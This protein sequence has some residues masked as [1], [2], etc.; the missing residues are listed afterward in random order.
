MG[1]HPVVVMPNS[2]F[3][4]QNLQ[5]HKMRSCQLS[6]LT[7]IRGIGRNRVVSLSATFAFFFAAGLLATLAV[8]KT[9]STGLPQE[10]EKKE[11]ALSW[12]P[13]QVDAPVPS[14]SATPP[15]SLPD[16]LNQAGARANE[17]IDHLQNF[18]AHE[19]IR[20]KQTDRDGAPDMT[21]AA[22]FDYTVD[23]EDQ[24]GQLNIHEARTPLDGT[25]DENLSDLLDK[26]LPALAL[27]FSPALQSDYEMRCDGLTPWNKQPTW[28]VRFRQIKGKRPRTMTMRTTTGAYPLALKGRAWIAKDS[29]QVM[30]LE[31]N[32][33]EGVP[34][35]DLQVNSVSVDYAP[36]K[37]Q[38]QNI[39]VWLPQFAVGYTDYA[40]RRMITEHTFSGFELFSIRT[41]QVIQKPKEP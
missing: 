40:K 37:F 24:S 26:G 5:S 23:F 3:G 17:L 1:Y 13:P 35:I 16:V 41:D 28:L 12:A 21:L 19:R 27:I 38:A 15:C 14:V 7:S 6:S 36:V 22:K 39:E 34:V 31:A 25:K 33:V 20:Y 4:A 9:L 32:L 30:H 8:A 18:I 11:H 10:K 2:R 29:G